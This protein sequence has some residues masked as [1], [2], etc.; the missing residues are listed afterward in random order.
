MNKIDAL[1]IGGQRCASTSIID[2]LSN[3][4]Q[5]IT[6]K[7]NEPEKNNKNRMVLS[8]KLNLESRLLNLSDFQE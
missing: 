7:N 5:V 8:I 6:P 2:F 1:I 3:L 4:K